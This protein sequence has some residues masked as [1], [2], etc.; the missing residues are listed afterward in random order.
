MG[1]FYV[2]NRDVFAGKCFWTER[3][4]RVSSMFSYDADYLSYDEGWNIDPS[5]ML[6]E[7]PQASDGELP[8]ALR[9]AAPD[10]WGRNLIQ[11]RHAKE[12]VTDRGRLRS[13]NEID[14]LLGVSDASRQGSLRFA[15][16]KGGAFQYPSD[17]VPKLIALPKLLGAADEYAAGRSAEAIACLLDAGSASLGGARPKASVSDDDRLYIAK[18][19]HRQ[20]EIDVIAWEWVALEM[21]S[22][23]GIDTPAHRLVNIDGRNVL[24]VERFDRRGGNRIGYISAMTALG[25]RDGERGDYREIAGRIYDLSLHVKEDLAELFRRIVF[26]LA[27]NNTDDHLKNH[28]FIADGSGWRLSPVFD[29]NPD[30]DASRARNT[31]VFG[32]T[33]RGAAL[34]SLM[35]RSGFFGLTHEQSQDILS[36][37]SAATGLYREFAGRAKV[38]QDASGLFKRIFKL[39]KSVISEGWELE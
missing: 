7:G 16:E 28:G 11:H 6:V 27:I 3:R 18:F 35:K 37:V 33:E 8:G 5:L 31:S 21:A 1:E 30:P 22:E 34:K 9:D 20:D 10:R 2:Y 12:H 15:I 13:L 17:D 14:Y 25:R 19:P 4:G 38:G 29:V 36:K 39:H 23:A 26:S 24:L 32:E